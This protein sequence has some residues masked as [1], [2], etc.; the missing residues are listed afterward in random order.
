M[1][2]QGK[3]VKRDETGSVRL[4]D[5]EELVRLRAVAADSGTEPCA[6]IQDKRSSSAGGRGPKYGGLRLRL[7]DC[8]IQG[9]TRPSIVRH[10]RRR[11]LSAKCVSVSRCLSVWCV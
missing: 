6:R 1:G 7:L 10:V 5:A 9:E 3:A 8:G 11:D 4:T 2:V